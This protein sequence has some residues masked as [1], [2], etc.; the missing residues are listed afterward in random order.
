MKQK[1]VVFYYGNY[2]VQEEVVGLGLGDL[3][4]AS[5]YLSSATIRED[6]ADAK[7][8]VGKF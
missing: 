8:E 4:I 7:S 5:I 1:A 6:A 2:R 3:P